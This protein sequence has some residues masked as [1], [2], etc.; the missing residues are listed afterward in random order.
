MGDNPEWVIDTSTYTHLCRAGHAEILEK[1]APG[2]VVVVPS[3]VSSEIDA[4]RERHAGIP[5]VSEVEWARLTVLTEAEDW[6]Q[7]L[8][9]AQMGGGP[10]EHLGECAVIACAHHRGMIA[11]L[12]ERAAIEQATRLE[13][14]SRDTL[15]LVIEAYKS[16]YGR[17][18]EQAI[19]VVDDLLET[20]MWLPFKSGESLF[21]WA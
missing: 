13:V 21:A 7:L 10:E 11:I 19:R 20:G 1:L 6:T 15:W 17:D 8:V 2:G 14:A 18:R 5:T 12:D 9:K 4:G 16:L 3:Q